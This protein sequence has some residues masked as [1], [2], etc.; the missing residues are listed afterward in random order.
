MKCSSDCYCCQEVI[1]LLLA[2]IV[3][4]DQMSTFNI[5]GLVLCLF[6]IVVHVI[7]KATVSRKYYYVIICSIYIVH[8]FKQAGVSGAVITEKV[9]TTNVQSVTAATPLH[10]HRPVLASQVSK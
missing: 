5:V 3:N 10:L 1:V 7:L 9:L 4:G 8:K 6:G 2:V